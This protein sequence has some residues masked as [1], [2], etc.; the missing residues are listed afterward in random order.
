SADRGH[1]V[2]VLRLSGPT[3]TGTRSGMTMSRLLL[4][5][6]G[7]LALFGATARSQTIIRPRGAAIA[8][9]P[10][11]PRDNQQVVAGTATLRGR[12]FA[13]D[14]GQPLRKAQVRIT[15]AGTINSGGQFP[16]NR[17]ATTDSNGRYLFT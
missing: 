16:E 9:Q 13:A 10:Q 6:V 15:G 2:G 11:P 3:S 5:L 14:T 7:S 8:G 12:V 1:A 17:L 4:A